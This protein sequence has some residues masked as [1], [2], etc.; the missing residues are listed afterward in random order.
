MLLSI[1]PCSSAKL[2][3]PCPLYL[4]YSASPVFSLNYLH[5]IRHSDQVLIL[6][7]K[8]GLVRPDKVAHPYNQR[9]VYSQNLAQ[10]VCMEISKLNPKVIYSYCGVGYNRIL[11][12]PPY[13]K[14]ASGSIVERAKQF[15]RQGSIRGSSPPLLKSLVWLYKN[16][17]CS[18]EAVAAFIF[19]T[20][21]NPITRKSQF[22][23]L[24]S[25]F[26]AK[27]EGDRVYYA[28]IPEDI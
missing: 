17:G 5:A 23:R 11:D 21:S 15:G 20:W 8:F 28:Y 6:S 1:V 13:I 18:L 14:P 4:L 27:V 10:S 16:S 25:S 12:S 22:S 26:F 2:P 9:L 7:G 3:V 19:S 24:L